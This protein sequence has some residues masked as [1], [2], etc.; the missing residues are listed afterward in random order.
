MIKGSEDD[1]GRLEDGKV[2]RMVQ[3]LREERW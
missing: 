1:L 2:T 3:C